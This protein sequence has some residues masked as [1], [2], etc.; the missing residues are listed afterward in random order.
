MKV[1]CLWATVA[2]F[3]GLIVYAIV[4]AVFDVDSTATVSVL[5]LSFT[6]VGLAWTGLR[7]FNF[8]LPGLHFEAGKKE[9]E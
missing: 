7:V 6:C 9:H 1:H 2:M 5:S 4:S 3:V 8:T